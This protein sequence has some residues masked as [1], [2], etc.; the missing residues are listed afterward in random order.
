[1][2]LRFHNKLNSGDSGS[3]LGVSIS[4]VRYGYEAA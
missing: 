4:P 3:L 1:M 2:V